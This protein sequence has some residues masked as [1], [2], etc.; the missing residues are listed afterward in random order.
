[1]LELKRRRE[2]LT[3][4]QETLAAWCAEQGAPLAC[5][6]DL[7][8]AIATLTG[9]GVLRLRIAAKEKPPRASG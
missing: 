4:S 8:D 7:L 9:W 1:M 2:N 6:D 3:K 5:N